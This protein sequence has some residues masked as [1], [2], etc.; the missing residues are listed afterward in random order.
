MITKPRRSEFA[1]LLYAGLF[2]VGNSG[3]VWV[4]FFALRSWNAT[5]GSAYR[6]SFS[7]AIDC[8]KFWSSDLCRSR[9]T[10]ALGYVPADLAKLQWLVAATLV[11]GII[12]IAIGGY[13]AF[14]MPPDKWIKSGRTV[15]GMP[16]LLRAA[17][18]EKIDKRDGL[19]WFNGWRLALERE[20]RH[21][22]IF[23]SIGGGKTQTM[24]GLIVS[25]IARHDKVLVFDIKG[26]LPRSC[27]QR[28]S[29]MVPGCSQSSLL[30]R[31]GGPMSGT[32]PRTCA[33]Q[34]MPLSW[35]RD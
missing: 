34:R 1:I 6:L 2:L 9:F 28:S 16:E 11:A 18:A 22:I 33:L 13:I 32:S 30:H 31:I 35:P 24:I 10:Q 17:K 4:Y 12:A 19:H 15:A 3:L 7:Q 5:N 20:V 26:D 25:A 14:L 29:R 8:L 23:G 27:L 21:F